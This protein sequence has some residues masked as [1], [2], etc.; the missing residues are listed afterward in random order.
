MQMQKTWE[1]KLY[2]NM[3]LTAFKAGLRTVKLIPVKS[4]IIVSSNMQG[5]AKFEL[6]LIVHNY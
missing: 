5:L 4:S 1:K 3:C 6:V 2:Q